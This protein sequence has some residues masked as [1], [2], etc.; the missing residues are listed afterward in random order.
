M[1]NE[2][3][4]ERLEEF[5]KIERDYEMRKKRM[6]DMEDAQAILKKFREQ[7]SLV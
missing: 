7:E 5:N 3:D 1:S 6:I 2:I 4:Q